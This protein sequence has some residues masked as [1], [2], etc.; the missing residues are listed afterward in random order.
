LSEFRD[1][2]GGRDHASLE[3]HFDAVNERVWR[4][5]LGGRNRASLEIHL[6]GVIER[7]GRCA[8]RP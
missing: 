2:L 7:V 8:W 5:A 4:Y 1:P 6:E 3:M